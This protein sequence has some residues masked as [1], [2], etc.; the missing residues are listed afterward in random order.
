M[1][2][3]P[4]ATP[5]PFHPFVASEE[6]TL[7]EALKTVEVPATMSASLRQASPTTPDPISQYLR[8][9]GTAAA[10][11]RALLDLE[12]TT[13]IGL[14]A[15]VLEAKLLLY[16]AAAWPTGTHVLSIR[17]IDAAWDSSAATWNTKP[18]TRATA[19]TASIPGLGAEGDL[20]EV[21]I[22]TL[23]TSSVSADDAAGARWHGLELALDTAGEK[24]FYS[25]FAPPDFRPKL[26]VKD[27][28]PPEVPAD[29]I[30]NGGRAVSE[31]RPE[32]VWRFF[33]QNAGDTIAFVQVQVDDVDDFATPVYDSAKVAQT[34]PRF[35]MAS[36]PAGAAAVSDLLPNSTYYW[37][38]RHWDSH[39]LV[40]DWG[41]PASFIIR[42][43]GTL[44]LLTP[45]GASVSSPTPTISWGSTFTQT[46]YRVLIERK[47]AGLWLAHWDTG[48]T[49]GTTTSVAVPNA[50]ALVENEQYRVT[51]QAKDNVDREDMPGDRAFFEATRDITLVALST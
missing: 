32:L 49:V 29:M 51:V 4:L 7:A 20:I 43:K 50:F 48:W 38:P 37:R 44:T 41:P 18:A 34:S 2:G 15:Q 19:V 42:I 8:L 46:Q 39:N 47:V 23:L 6:L 45:S 11:V 26:R 17:A 10:E 22:T 30:P 40:S 31:V 9:D 3:L 25:A 27:N 28:L 5:I 13:P 33:D 21:D 16:K 35:D 1:S 24:K 14:G 12:R 36:P